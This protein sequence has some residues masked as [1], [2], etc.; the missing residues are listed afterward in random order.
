MFSD[1]INNNDR[2][3]RYLIFVFKQEEICTVLELI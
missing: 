2:F 3:R 1:A